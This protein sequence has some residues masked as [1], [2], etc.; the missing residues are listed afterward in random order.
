[1]TTPNAA[2]EQDEIIHSSIWADV[3]SIVAEG[4]V[5]AAAGVVVAG[6]ALVATPFL[7]AFGAA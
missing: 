5:Y 6:A 3:V 7:T 2:R 1:M 4:V